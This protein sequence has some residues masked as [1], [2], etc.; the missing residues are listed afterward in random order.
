MTRIVRPRALRKNIC[1][2]TGYECLRI[3]LRR[4]RPYP[5]P[6]MRRALRRLL[7]SPPHPTP[8]LPEG[9]KPGTPA[10]PRCAP[11]LT[12][13]LGTAPR[14]A[15]ARRP[16]PSRP[17]VPRLSRGP[18]MRPPPLAPASRHGS[19]PATLRAGAWCPD[20]WGRRRRR[21]HTGSAASERSRAPPVG[22][23]GRGRRRST[24]RRLPRLRGTL[25]HASPPP[26]PR[27]LT[28][29]EG[30]W[31]ARTGWAG[32]PWTPRLRKLLRRLS[33]GRL[34]PPAGRADT[35]HAPHS[36][37]SLE[38]P[39]RLAFPGC[40]GPPGTGEEGKTLDERRNASSVRRRKA[41][42][43]CEECQRF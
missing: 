35:A 40:C 21:R 29:D 36:W 12:A 23:P 16:P 27:P 8:T 2:D 19:R 22:A 14:S 5:E 15:A 43:G 6:R 25:P 28:R 10:R 1:T 11:R 9:N 39:A 33:G 34:G 42:R 38:F 20:S 32:S 17:P 24:A 31:P 26:A 7:P 30:A 37:S 4:R 41:R 18:G 13:R 3:P